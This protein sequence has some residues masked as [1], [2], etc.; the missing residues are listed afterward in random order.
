[1]LPQFLILW[2]LPEENQIRDGLMPKRNLSQCGVSSDV[3]IGLIAGFTTVPEMPA[4]RPDKFYFFFF[5]SVLV[6]SC[7]LRFKDG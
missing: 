4:A 7:H 5:S 3:F 2:Q 6:V 1:M